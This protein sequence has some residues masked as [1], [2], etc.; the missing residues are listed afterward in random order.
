[1]KRCTIDAGGAEPRDCPELAL[2]QMATE[3][4]Q[5]LVY[6]I[7]EGKPLLYK[8]L[9]SD[10]HS[11][12]FVIYQELL[13]LLWLKG[14]WDN[15]VADVEPDDAEEKTKRYHAFAVWFHA[16]TGEEPAYRQSGDPR[17]FEAV[18]KQRARLRR[19]II[20]FDERGRDL[21]ARAEI[22]F[23]KQEKMLRDR[24][25]KLGGDNP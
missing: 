19:E 16:F 20:K 15:L 1:M 5:A 12:V 8:M 18:M 22:A 17:T 2:L 24:I 14:H 6:D 25:R 3:G 9:Y 23:L 11:E 10:I 7:L 21:T 13:D 4:R